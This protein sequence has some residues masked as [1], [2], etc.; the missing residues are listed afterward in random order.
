MFPDFSTIKMLYSWGCLSPNADWYVQMNRLTAD[1]YKEL[2]GE[3]YTAPT[4]DTTTA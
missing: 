2:T 4:T 1:Q 3:D